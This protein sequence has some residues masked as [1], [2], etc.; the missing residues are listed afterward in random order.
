MLIRRTIHDRVQTGK[1]DK[2]V[3][4]GVQFGVG[5]ALAVLVFI[6]HIYKLKR[7]FQKKSMTNSDVDYESLYDNSQL[8]D[9]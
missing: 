3:A 4:F 8:M 9:K 6:I 7:M 2:T 1:I 5:L